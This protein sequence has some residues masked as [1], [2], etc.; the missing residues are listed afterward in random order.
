[1]IMEEN[2]SEGSEDLKPKPPPKRAPRGIRSFTVCRQHD[3]TGVSGEGVIIEGV[4]LASGHCIIHWLFPP[5]RGGIAIFD[6]LE[7]FLKV[8][9]KPHPENKTI[10]TFEDGEQKE[11]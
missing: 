7:D 5:P 6:S 9:V 8:H 1:M 11:Y 2:K 3:E 10:I 4:V